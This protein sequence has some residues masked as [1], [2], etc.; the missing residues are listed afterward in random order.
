MTIQKTGRYGQ[1]QADARPPNTR[2]A[3]QAL[4]PLQ[5]K[6]V[7]AY[8]ELGG[9]KGAEAARLAGYGGDRNTLKAQ[10]WKLLHEP[11]V[12]DAI[13]EEADVKLRCGAV[14]GASV[15]SE[16][17]DD[18][19]H[20]DRFKAA[21]A[22]LDRAGLLVKH[23]QHI[24][25]EHTAS[26]QEKIARIV[27]MAKGLGLDP[28]VLLGQAGIQYVDAEFAAVEPAALPKPQPKQEIF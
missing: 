18:P 19:T 16:I 4:T 27:T 13:R 9:R 5:R 28:A 20:K 21:Q 14:L 3:L 1:P 7:D 2:R 26:D 23:E 6:F 12:L 22:L 15:L 8:V 10:A 17:A 11:K 24:V 25:V